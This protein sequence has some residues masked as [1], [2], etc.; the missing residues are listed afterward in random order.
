MDELAILRID[1]QPVI[2]L[3]S[4]MVRVT[5]QRESILGVLSKSSRP[6]SPAEILAL[7]RVQVPHIGMA[8]I[9]RTLKELLS[10]HRVTLV[11][12]PGASP[13]YELHQAHHHHHFYC[14]DCKQVFELEGCLSNVDSLAPQRFIVQRHEIVLYGECRDC[15]S[16]PRPSRS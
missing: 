13:H 5:K 14:L 6:L 7:A 11:E 10:E 1:S 4:G 15:A 8:T 12:I 2:G 3:Q 16:A 9:Y